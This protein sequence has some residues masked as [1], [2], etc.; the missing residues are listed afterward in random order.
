MSRYERA[1]GRFSGAAHDSGAARAKRTQGG[2][3]RAG[4]AEW[5]VPMNSP[6][7]AAVARSRNKYEIE[8][9]L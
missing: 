6:Q 9:K 5:I 7:C 3:I 8:R 1:T 2:A 4:R